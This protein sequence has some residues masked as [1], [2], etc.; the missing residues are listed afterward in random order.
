MNSTSTNIYK[1]C[2]EKARM[3]Q[4]VASDKLSVGLRTLATYEAYNA[5][6]LE[7]TPPPEDIILKM[8]EVYQ[9]PQLPLKHLAENTAIGRKY[10]PT[11][12]LMELPVAFLRFQQEREEVEGLETLMRNAI[13]D[14]KISNDE[15][16]LVNRFLKEISDLTVIGWAFFYSILEKCNDYERIERLKLEGRWCL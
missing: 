16:E 15:Q 8:A 1:L 11:F 9:A 10:I 4:T 12:E 6:K 5:G 14:N 2:R 3:T 7:G 13:I